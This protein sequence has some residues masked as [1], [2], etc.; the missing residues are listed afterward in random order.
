[1]ELKTFNQF[2]L[3][4]TNAVGTVAREEPICHYISTSHCQIGNGDR[5][6]GVGSAKMG[7]AR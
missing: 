4:G 6:H 1:M 2:N 5:A 3:M 7:D